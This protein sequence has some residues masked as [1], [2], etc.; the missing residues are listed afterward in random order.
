ADPTV[1]LDDLMRSIRRAEVERQRAA[2]AAPL[3]EKRLDESQELDLLLKI[4][5]HEKTRHG[6]SEPTDG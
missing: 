2:Q 3:R 6:I 1:L 5:R 4:V